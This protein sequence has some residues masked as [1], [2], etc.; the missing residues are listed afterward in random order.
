MRK[1]RT[2]LGL[3]RGATGFLLCLCLLPC[4]GSAVEQRPNGPDQVFTWKAGGLMPD[5]NVLFADWDKRARIY[6]LSDYGF[7]MVNAGS[8][9]HPKPAY[10]LGFLKQKR[11]EVCRTFPQFQAALKR[12]PRGAR[13]Y[14]YTVCTAGTAPGVSWRAYVPV[15]RAFRKGHLK[16]NPER[17]IMYECCGEGADPRPDYPPE[18]KANYRKVFGAR[19]GGKP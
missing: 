4:L 8:E 16:F 15:E 7:M 5:G 11:V 18:L 14:H 17:H 10:L 13:V 6:L 9:L 2:S 1:G 19:S 12:I 3:L